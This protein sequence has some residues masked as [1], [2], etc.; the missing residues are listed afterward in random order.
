MYYHNYWKHSLR[1]TVL[2]QMSLEYDIQLFLYLK[3]NEKKNQIRLKVRYYLYKKNLIH[4]YIIRLSGF[5]CNFE[6]IIKSWI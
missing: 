4:F 6:R 3:E 5:N 2:D 1:S